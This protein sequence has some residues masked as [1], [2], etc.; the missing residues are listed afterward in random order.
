MIN[1][2]EDYIKI[3]CKQDEKCGQKPT[4]PVIKVQ[5]KPADKI[6]KS[7]GSC[8]LLFCLNALSRMLVHD[9]QVIP[10]MD[11]VLSHAVHLL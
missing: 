1:V 5:Y 9:G 3:L 8:L 11:R 6:I 10:I 2:S 7:A 4:Y